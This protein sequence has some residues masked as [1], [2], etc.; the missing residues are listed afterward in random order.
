M[1]FSLCRCKLHILHTLLGGCFLC[2]IGS[3][4]L[5]LTHCTFRKRV[6][7][8]GHL[9]VCVSELEVAVG[10]FAHV[11]YLSFSL[12]C[13]RRSKQYRIGTR[14]RQTNRTGMDI[15][16]IRVKTKLNS[17]LSRIF[18]FIS[19]ITFTFKWVE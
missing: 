4:L 12:F 5:S 8:G 11:L 6:R 10:F 3:H 9:G 16:K 15:N 19:I 7:D 2:K 14:H 1:I 18:F 17:R 13:K